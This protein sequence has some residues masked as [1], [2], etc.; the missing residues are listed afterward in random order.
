MTLDDLINLGLARHPKLQQAEIAVETA[1]G[2]AIQAGLYPNPVLNITGDELGDITGPGGIWTPL[3]MQEIVVKKKLPLARAA[4]DRTV[5]Q[6]TWHVA[7]Q[8]AA[9]M[10]SIRQAYFDLL[11]IQARLNVQTQLVALGE[12][13]VN[14]VEKLAAGNQASRIDILQLTVELERFR[15]DAN[16]V[17]SELPAAF[18]RLAAVIG[19]V[20]LPAVPIIGMLEAP[21][22]VYDLD[23]GRQL[24]LTVHPDVQ[25]ARIGVDK[26]QLLLARARVEPFP[27]P[28]FGAGYTRQSQNR[29]N[30]YSVALAFPVP[31]WN[32]NQGNIRA[33]QAQVSDALQEVNRV[34]ADLTDR[35]AIAFRE[36]AAARQRAEHY[37]DA[38]LPRARE[39]AQLTMQAHLAGQFEAL[40]VLV[41]QSAIA[42]ARLE[43]VKS[44]GDAWKAAAAL[45]GLT[46][47]E[48][49]PPV[50]P[51]PVPQ[52][53]AGGERK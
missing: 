52:P 36:Y 53:Q 15:A 50:S 35:F 25:S 23:R 19:V 51:E 34:E 21:L 26:S 48:P 28:T 30:D 2:L 18:R 24:V 5:D 46:L 45:A 31:L 8:R 41:A 12:Q 29:S 38:V 11:T 3:V 40:K 4:A 27:N 49:W 7:G 33:A 43:L 39:L 44:Y 1:R 20:D 9:M 13:S 6:A 42:N 22:P 32:R 17:R 37:R 16:A 14:T 10:T 47:E